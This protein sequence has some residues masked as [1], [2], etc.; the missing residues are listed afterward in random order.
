MNWQGFT[1]VTDAHMSIGLA[2]RT[3]HRLGFGTATHG[4]APANTWWRHRQESVAVLRRAVD[5]G[6][7]FIDTADSYGEGASEQLIAEALYPYVADLLIATKGGYVMFPKPWTPDGRPEHLRRVC[8]ESLGRLRLDRIDLYQLHSPDPAV[9]F[10]DTVGALVELREAGK[11]GH[12]GL[13]NVDEGHLVRAL[14]L[15]PIASV[16]NRYN[17]ADRSSEA[18]LEFCSVHGIAFIPWAPTLTGPHK[19]LSEVAARSRATERQ[20]ALAWLLSRSRFVLP[21]PGT[22]VIAHLEENMG[23]TSTNLSEQD[24][25]RLTDEKA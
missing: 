5:L 19:A 10:E 7:Q 9:P 24:M 3:V 2:G 20:V 22:S 23:A 12:I 15:T 11:I 16:Q 21:I 25:L 14:R 6:V 1:V 8:D 17:L 4:A 18:V 13:S